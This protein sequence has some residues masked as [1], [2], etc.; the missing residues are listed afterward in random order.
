[1]NFVVDHQLPPALARFLAN[2]GHIACHVREMGLKKAD[3][4]S[5]W[6]RAE[7]ED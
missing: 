3:D 5:I 2:Q 4:A 6:R 1:V 7:S